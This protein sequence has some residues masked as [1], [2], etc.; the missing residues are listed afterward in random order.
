MIFCRINREVDEFANSRP[1]L[2]SSSLESDR[3]IDR[4]V[5]E[6]RW[7]AEPRDRATR[8]FHC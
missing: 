6:W 8:S 5:L 4:M 3:A 2:A 1:D 7:I